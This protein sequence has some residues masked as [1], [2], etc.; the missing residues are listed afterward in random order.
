MTNSEIINYFQD[1]ATVHVRDSIR[2]SKTG[3]GD[4]AWMSQTDWMG[5]LAFR[6][7]S[8]DFDGPQIREM[9][10]ETKLSENQVR[11]LLEKATA[12]AFDY[13]INMVRLDAEIAELEAEDVRQPATLDTR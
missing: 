1:L 4:I 3:N 11:V 5:R 12:E 13:E 8:D 6:T 9:M 2:N 7:C 10:D